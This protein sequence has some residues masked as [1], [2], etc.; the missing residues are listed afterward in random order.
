M[1][2]RPLRLCSACLLGVNCRY[3]GRIKEY[4]RVLDL[5]ADELLIPVCPEQLGGQPTPREDAEIVGTRVVTKSGADCT[6]EFRRGAEEVLKIARLLG[7]KKA[8]LKQRSPSCGS[9]RVYDGTFTKT[10][11]DGDGVTTAL[12][13]E[14][15]IEVISEEDLQP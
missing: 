2:D 8:I 10:L 13:K 3:D 9:G 1:T 14:N 4:P 11:R 7:I 5:L 12:L 6:A 15:G